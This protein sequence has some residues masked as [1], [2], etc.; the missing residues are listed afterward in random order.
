MTGW[1][2][3]TAEGLLSTELESFKDVD[4]FLTELEKGKVLNQ[5]SNDCDTY[6]KDFMKYLRNVLIPKMM[7][8][9]FEFRYLYHRVY[10][11]GSYYDGLRIVSDSR[12][13][14]L[15]VNIVL[16]LF[17]PFMRE[18]IHESNVHF[19][20]DISVPNG[21]VRI[22]C[23]EGC[24]N[25]LQHKQGKKF[26]SK[27][28][29]KRININKD[30]ANQN[31]PNLIQ[32]YLH[33]NKTLQWFCKL[34][35]QAT[36]KITI[37]DIK[38][39]TSFSKVPKVLN[40]QGPSQK[41]QVD[42]NRASNTTPLLDVDL[43]VAFEFDVNFYEP[44]D[45]T[46]Q[47]L[48][49]LKYDECERPC[50]FVIPK[51]LQTKK[52]Q[53]IEKQCGSTV[54]SDSLNW[55]IDFHD[56]ERI[57]LNPTKFPL[58]KPAIKILKLYKYVNTLKLSSYLIKSMVMQ[59]VVKEKERTVFMADSKLDDAIIYTLNVICSCLQEGKVPYLFDQK[60]NLFW[61][62]SSDDLKYMHIKIKKDIARLKNE[63][64]E[65]W[66]KLLIKKLPLIDEFS[67]IN[68]GAISSRSEAWKPNEKRNNAYQR[69]YRQL[70]DHDADDPD[71]DDVNKLLQ[72]THIKKPNRVIKKRTKC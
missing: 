5:N 9:S 30:C 48:R 53:D 38:G 67:F 25:K 34:V 33:P 41:I 28:F 61:K 65:A 15:D 2:Q 18:Y 6:A 62:T 64:I 22:L 3:D 60:C 39:I 56:Q 23:E 59:I 37:H 69:N 52:Q 1:I 54:K 45:T 47:S 72:M 51:I 27:P 32:Y 46:N 40:K 35:K 43:V 66:H 24:I 8:I 70:K 71:L 11:T 7:E 68:N 58:A 16:S 13:T 10:E 19:N 17:T 36:E 20:N 21:F 26:Q 57:I 44:N 4:H 29:F 55:R 12:R 42:L 49:Y 50:L 63:G 31:N 14:E